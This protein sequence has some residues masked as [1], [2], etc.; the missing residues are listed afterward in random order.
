[1]RHLFILPLLVL[2]TQIA[3]HAQTFPDST[4]LLVEMAD[5]SR[6]EGIQLSAT[7]DHIVLDAGEIG[8]V[9]L[10]RS[11]IYLIRAIDRPNPDIM[12]L[13]IQLKDRSRI[14]GKKMAFTPTQVILEV[15]GQGEVSIDRKD[16]YKIK[17]VRQNHRN[18][19]VFV[20]DHPILTR[21]LF[22][23]SAFSLEKGQH[24]Y[25]TWMGLGHHFTWG[26]TDEL[27]IG[28]TTELLSLIIGGEGGHPSLL[29]SAK[30][31]IPVQ[32]DIWQLAIGT[33]T[34]NVSELIKPLNTDRIVDFGMFYVLSTLGNKNYNITLAGGP[35]LLFG[36]LKVGSAFALSSNLRISDHY[37]ITTEN[38]IIP[39]E[40]ERG[41]V[42]T[43]GCR[44]INRKI[45][46]DFALGLAMESGEGGRFYPFPLV[47]L[48]MP[49]HTQP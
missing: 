22:G 11:N 6:F 30:Y 28:A 1:M 12:Y 36:D 26:V 13:R 24:T 33:T 9:R 16:I 4:L 2:W 48:T 49:L 41:S 7:E 40:D 19:K 39:L 44:Y 46:W 17:V 34:G 47:G 23:P 20:T 29:I 45:S 35:T 14:E 18:K 32:S 21:Y 37:M 31:A 27:S 15:E 25:Q 8:E 3:T 5:G 43:L 38:Y 10:L 42:V